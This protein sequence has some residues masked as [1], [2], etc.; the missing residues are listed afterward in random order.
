MK[1]YLLT[2]AIALTLIGCAASSPQLKWQ[3]M[4]QAPR[5]VVSAARDTWADTPL[6]P[7]HEPQW[8]WDHANV[9][10]A[11]DGHHLVWVHYISS[12]R[13]KIWTW[14][15]LNPQNTIIASGGYSEG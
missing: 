7:T 10:R 3:P 5:D 15:Q 14:F 12:L 13:G 1:T 6:P 4:S 2:L 11:D 9:F 8:Q